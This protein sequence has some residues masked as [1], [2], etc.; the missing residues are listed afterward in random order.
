M[1]QGILKL[2]PHC[3]KNFA[4]WHY[5]ENHLLN[6]CLECQNEVDKAIQNWRKPQTKR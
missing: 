2:C 3:R 1:F 6:A 4:L 5:V